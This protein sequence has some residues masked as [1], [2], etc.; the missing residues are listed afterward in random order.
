MRFLPILAAL[1][2]SALP[3][4]PALALPDWNEPAASGEDG[5]PRLVAA[6]FRSGWCGACRVLEPRVEDVR[7]E[8]DSADIDWVR[9]DFTWGERGGVRDIAVAEGIAPLYDRLAG[10][11]GFL[12][13]MDRETGQVFEIVTMDYGRD[14]IREALE[15]WLVVMERLESVEG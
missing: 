15:R 6:L 14:R 13:L 5:E 9:L 4:A 11:T 1:F 3:A 7:R 8:Y 12:V 2:L 10:R